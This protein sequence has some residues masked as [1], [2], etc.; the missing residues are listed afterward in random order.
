MWDVGNYVWEVEIT[1]LGLR[2]RM[3]YMF[4]W[5]DLLILV[6]NVINCQKVRYIWVKCTIGIDINFSLE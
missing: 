3:N 2:I 5:I 4:K 1:L 6:I